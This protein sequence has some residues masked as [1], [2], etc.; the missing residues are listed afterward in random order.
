MVTI[1]DTLR[2][3]IF[4]TKIGV[5]TML[6]FNPIYTISTIGY[7]GYYNFFGFFIITKLI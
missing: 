3:T 1:Y 5:I 7:L 6:A 4:L 2:N